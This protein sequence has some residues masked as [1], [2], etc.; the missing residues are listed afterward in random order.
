[1]RFGSKA[2]YGAGTR[3]EAKPLSYEF[4]KAWI[5]QSGCSLMEEVNGN[6]FL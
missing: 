6:R 5:K 3:K 4:W 1:M 2:F